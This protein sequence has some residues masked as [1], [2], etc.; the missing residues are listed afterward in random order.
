MAVVGCAE[1]QC[2]GAVGRGRVVGLPGEHYDT[3]VTSADGDRLVAVRV[4][5]EDVPGLV[6]L[7]VAVPRSAPA[8]R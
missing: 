1:G 7:E 3:A 2:V 6:E 8:S 4:P 5:R